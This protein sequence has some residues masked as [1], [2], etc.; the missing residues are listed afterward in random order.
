[1]NNFD[2]ARDALLHAWPGAPERWAAYLALGDREPGHPY[3][4]LG[5]VATWVVSDMLADRTEG[6]VHLF[7]AIEEVLATSGPEIRKILIVGLLEGI[8]NVSLNRNVP[9]A[10]YDLWLGPETRKGWDVLNDMWAGRIT[11]E[12]FNRR[13]T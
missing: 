11:P 12:E 8:Q 10:R 4:D 3:T 7:A 5:E 13:A 9:L 1:V 2:G 6:L